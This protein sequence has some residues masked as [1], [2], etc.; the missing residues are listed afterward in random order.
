[1][2]L[3]WQVEDHDIYKIR[4]FYDQHKGNNFVQRRYKRNIKRELPEFSNSLFWGAMVSCLLTTQQRSGPE[5][6]V[7]RFISTTPFPLN[8]EICL[9]Q[10]NLGKFA[11][12]SITEFGGI[13]RGPTIGDEI[14][15]NFQ[16]LEN[17]GWNTISKIVETLAHG[18]T[19]ETEMAAAEKIAEHLKGFGPKQARNLLQALGL[20]KYEI[21]I[22]SRIT[23]WMNNIGFPIELS[24]TALSDKN[25]YSFISEGFRKL[26]DASDIYPCML[27]AA[28]F[29]SFDSD[30][31]K[32]RLVW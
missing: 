22:D 30:W 26:C 28:I 27:D 5:S 4:V 20:T 2:K 14:Q 9:K 3:V 21:P 23:K 13:R 17:D 6:A 25:Y 31:P 11:E 15:H 1:M 10:H 16:W 8:Y 19:A 32:D 29:S 18:Q 7:T 24:A 12:T